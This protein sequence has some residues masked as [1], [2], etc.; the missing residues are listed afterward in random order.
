[1][2]TAAVRAEPPSAPPTST[3]AGTDHTV[4]PP[5]QHPFPPPSPADDV[6]GSVPAPS[7]AGGGSGAPSMAATLT[8]DPRSAT[9]VPAVST[10][11]ARALS[12]GSR[13]EPAVSPD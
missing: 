13:I 7:S 10:A 8:A 12:A 9:A 5:A 3:A 2:S 6:P 11:P 1:V 4:A